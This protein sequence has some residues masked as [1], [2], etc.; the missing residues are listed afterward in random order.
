M[1]TLIFLSRLEISG[2]LLLIRPYTGSPLLST[3][4]PP[5]SRKD[6]ASARL[7]PKSQKRLRPS[8]RRTLFS[9]ELTGL[10]QRMCACTG[11][12][13]P[14]TEAIKATQV[15]WWDVSRMRAGV[16]YNTS[17]IYFIRPLNPLALLSTARLLDLNTAIPRQN[18]NNSNKLAHWVCE[19]I[20]RLQ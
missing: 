9:L 11:C 6:P 12:G 14:R 18:D 10:S 1:C 15:G 13:S 20:F 16:V 3:A 8:R 4:F 7:L 5:V 19:V 2:S 17:V